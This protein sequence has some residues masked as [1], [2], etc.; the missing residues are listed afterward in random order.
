M[1]ERLQGLFHKQKPATENIREPSQTM[2]LGASIILVTRTRGIDSY[3]SFINE[4][5]PQVDA[6]FLTGYVQKAKSISEIVCADGRLAVYS[7]DE[8][9]NEQADEMGLVVLVKPSN[10]QPS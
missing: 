2:E 5:F 8:A 3:V 1:L 9:K 10:E 6:F 4:I 7:V